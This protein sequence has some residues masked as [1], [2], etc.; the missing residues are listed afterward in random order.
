MSFI[1]LNCKDCG[2]IDDSFMVEGPIWEA[3]GLQPRDIVCLSCLSQRLGR[4]LCMGDFKIVPLNFMNLPGFSTEE[5]YRKLYAKD[6]LDYDQTKT[7]YF[8]RCARLGLEPHWPLDEA[9]SGYFREYKN[10]A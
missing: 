5:N 2:Q 3:A 6:G 10:H 1:N 4:T 8:E 7:E 9:M